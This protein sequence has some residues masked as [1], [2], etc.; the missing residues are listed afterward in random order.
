MCL[1]IGVMTREA[2]QKRTTFVVVPKGD[3]RL[4]PETWTLAASRVQ[5]RLDLIA[6]ALSSLC[7]PVV[8]PEG[9]VSARL[10]GG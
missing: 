1:S 2:R 9:N 5:L 3:H 7:R 10:L 4:V 6:S 8:H